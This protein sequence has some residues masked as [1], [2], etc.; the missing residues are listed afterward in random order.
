MLRWSTALGMDQEWLAS[1]YNVKQNLPFVSH[2]PCSHVAQGLM[3]TPVIN[4][5]KCHCNT[6][7]T[8][9]RV[10]WRFRGREK[11]T[12]TSHRGLAEDSQSTHTDFTEDSQRTHRGLAEDSQRTHRGCAEDSQRTRRRLTEESGVQIWT[13]FVLKPPRTPRPELR[14]GAARNEAQLPT[15]E[16]GPG[17]TPCTLHALQLHLPRSHARH[18]QKEK[19]DTTKLIS[20]LKV[21]PTRQS[22]RLSDLEV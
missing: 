15:D 18:A 2:G 4:K 13:H 17:K 1:T 7:M 20:S 19:E 14:R 12:Q 3:R 11:S 9:L 16:A 8:T 10:I 6:D 22:I 21:A 5:L